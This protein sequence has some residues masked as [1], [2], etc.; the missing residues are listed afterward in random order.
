MD[1]ENKEI[2]YSDFASL[3]SGMSSVLQGS[4]LK[5]GVKKDSVFK[6]WP[7]VVGKKFE[8][9]SSPETINH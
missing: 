2:L 1:K 5:Q 9:Y 4:N 8:K 7:K 3:G 6:F